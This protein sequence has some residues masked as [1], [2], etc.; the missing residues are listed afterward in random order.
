M[1]SRSIATAAKAALLSTILLL[2]FIMSIENIV[3]EWSFIL[4]LS[5]F[6]TFIISIGMIFSTILPFYFIES[7]RATDSMI[8]NKY[9]PYYSIVFFSC[10]L[11]IVL[12]QKFDISVIVIS[13]IAYLTA[14]QSWIWMFK[15]KHI[16]NE[17]E[18]I[19]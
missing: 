5:L 14:M 12:E 11:L 1:I 7:K 10:C 19:N 18:K 8:F 15:P 2:L 4:I 17:K 6:V 16:K 9:F 13:F 3:N